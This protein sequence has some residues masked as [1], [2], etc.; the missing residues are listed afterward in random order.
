MTRSSVLGVSCF[1][2]SVLVSVATAS[3][4][5]AGEIERHTTFATLQIRPPQITGEV[6]LPT[7]TFPGI[8]EIDRDGD[9]TYSQNELNSARFLVERF[10]RDSLFVLWGGRIQPIQA[11]VI[12]VAT[13][14][15]SRRSYFKVSIRVR[16]YA[17]GQDVAIVSRMFRHLAPGA[18]CVADITRDGRRELFVLGPT[19]YYDT[20]RAAPK[21]PRDS[22][23]RPPEQRGRIASFRDITLEM[24]YAMPAGAFTLYYLESDRYTPHAIDAKSVT[25]S[26]RPKDGGRTD[27]VTLTA[28]PLPTDEKGKCSRFVAAATGMK[29]HDL[30]NADINLTVGTESSRLIFDFPAVNVERAAREKAAPKRYACSRWCIGVQTTKQSTKCPRCGSALLPVRGDGIPGYG[31]IGPH[32]G[33]LRE[34][35]PQVW[36]EAL[37][38]SRDELR[39]YVTNPELARRS[40]GSLSGT[41]F[42]STDAH[43]EETGVEVTLEAAEEGKFFRATVPESVKLPI[44]AR[45]NLQTSG[46]GGPLQAD[47]FLQG[48]NPID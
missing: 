8:S 7:D 22:H 16:D 14:P 46:E 4:E 28:K 1:V 24:L 25:A 35:R 18:R 6:W 45:C 44:R 38:T 19:R 2:I 21:I 13:R 40:V 3:A 5:T 47:F 9:F 17:P 26:I 29:G 32:G 48:L 33:E 12:E 20:A 30:F 41:V 10:L 23:Y 31:V 37:L 34:L 36:I 42:L 15:S 27:K 11:S 43:F 39:L